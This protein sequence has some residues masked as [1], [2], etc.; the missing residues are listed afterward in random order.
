ME[1]L[2]IATK[3]TAFIQE[4]LLDKQKTFIEQLTKGGLNAFEENLTE[5]LQSFYNLISEELL[6]VS[7]Q[8][9]EPVLRAELGRGGPAA[10]P[11]GRGGVFV[12]H[13]DGDRRRRGAHPH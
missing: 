8:A 2:T 6:A 7:A 11:R 1:Q 13:L 5:V 9:A 10:V 3:V 12:R 4:H